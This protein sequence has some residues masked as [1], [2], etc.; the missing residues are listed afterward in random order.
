MVGASEAYIRA[1]ESGRRNPKPSSL[2]TIANA[3]SVNTEVLANSDFDGIKAIH[4]L[5]QIFRQYDGHLFECQDKDGND[6]VSWI[7]GDS[8]SVV[9]TEKAEELG[10]ENLAASVDEKGNI[11]VNGLLHGME[12]TLSERKPADGY[13]TASDIKFRLDKMVNDEGEVTTKVSVMDE[14]GNYVNS[15]NN[16][17]VMYD[18][19]TKVDFS[20]TDITGEK[21]VPGCDLEV[22]DKDT[23]KVMDQ[24]TSTKHKHMTE[25]KYVVGKTYVMTEKRPADGFVTAD[26]VEF[27]IADTGKVQGVSMKDDTTKIEFSKIASDTKKML[28]HA[29][30][31]QFCIF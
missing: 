1:Y 30:F 2:A 21:E 3:L 10:Y 19:T 18:D 28:E 23:G 31:V 22:T 25:G 20:K 12:Y 15:N 24:W 13:V 14:N 27:T 26:S 6:I 5:F 9:I 17:V 29:V 7:S 11:I 4:R 16:K 8:E